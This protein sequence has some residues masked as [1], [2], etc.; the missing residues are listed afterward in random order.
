MSTQL[1]GT[2]LLDPAVIDDPYPFYSELQARA[3]VW[4][5]P[6]TGIFTVAASGLVTEAVGRTEDFSSNLKCLLYRDGEGQPCR[7]PFG[8]AGAQ[9]LATAD[10]PMHALHRST[11][12]PE[13]I[14]KRMTALEPDI[15]GLADECVTRALER[16]T[17]EFMTAIGNVVPIT[18]TSRLIGF[19]DAD[20]DQLLSAAFD[21]TAMLGSALTFDELM[22]LVTRVAEIQEWITGQVAAA[23]QD[24]GADILGAVASGVNGGVFGGF[25]ATSIL[26]ILLSA[27]GEST[28]SLLGNAV[29]LLAE[30]PD[31]QDHLRGNPGLIPRFVEEAVRLESPFRY[32]MRSVAR[33]TTLGGVSLP[34]DATLLLLFGAA[35]RDAAEFDRPDE[36]DLR[37]RQPRQHLAFGRGIHYCVGAPLARVEARIVL[38]VLLDRTASVTLDP[39]HPPR[40]VQSLMV[41]R[42]E[43][44]PIRLAPRA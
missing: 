11:V 28:T 31:L 38:S 27:G 21:S 14:A 42:H 36:L 37:R 15:T 2:L 13:L 29:R 22:Q 17:A 5:I 25:E 16:G 19:R 18:V 40:W 43:E 24:P 35:N 23:R 9:A 6:G 26:H 32:Q 10:P 33:D 41:R 12:F 39:D 8:D 44:L 3:P 20:V 1:S 7:L 4:E 34:A 30:R